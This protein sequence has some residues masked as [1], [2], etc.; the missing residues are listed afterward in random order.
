LVT[1]DEKKKKKEKD[2]FNKKKSFFLFPAAWASRR[3]EMLQ[4]LGLA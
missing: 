2:S 1:D 3:L 4:P